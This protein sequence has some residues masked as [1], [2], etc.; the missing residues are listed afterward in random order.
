MQYLTTVKYNNGVNSNFSG[1]WLP[2]TL[3]YSFTK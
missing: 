1:G 3:L 2:V